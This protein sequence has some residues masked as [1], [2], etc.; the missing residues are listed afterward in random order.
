MTPHSKRLP[1]EG[2]TT[3]TM[4]GATLFLPSRRICSNC[5]LNRNFSSF[6]RRKRSALRLSAPVCSVD[7]LAPYQAVSLARPF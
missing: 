3:T 5:D 4:P 1:G 6:F 2:A 7:T